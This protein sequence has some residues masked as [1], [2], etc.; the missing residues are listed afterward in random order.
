MEIWNFNAINVYALDSSIASSIKST[1][2]WS[3]DADGMNEGAINSIK[4]Q[5]RF[6]QKILN[7]EDNGLSLKGDFENEFYKSSNDSFKEQI[8]FQKSLICF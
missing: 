8:S 2:D 1:R 7:G 4:L 5:E 6:E 3:K